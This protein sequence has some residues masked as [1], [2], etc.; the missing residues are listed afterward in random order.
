VEWVHPSWR[1]LVIEHLADDAAT[2]AHFLSGCSAHGVLL[3]LSLAGGSR[4]DRELPLLTSDPDWDAL[5]DRIYRLV[6]ELDTPELYAVLDS[7]GGAIGSLDEP[8]A[9]LEAKALARTVLSHTAELWD[10][11]RAPLPLAGLEAWLALADQLP[12]DPPR[13]RPPNLERTWVELLPAT[14]PSPEHRESVERFADWLT[15][16]DILREHR[17]GYL[18]RFHFRDHTPVINRFLDKIERDHRRLDPAAHDHALRALRRIETLVPSLLEVC[19]YFSS[20]LRDAGGE[21]TPEPW[22]PSAE[23]LAGEREGWRLFDVG[24]V[25]EDL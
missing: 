21:L 10:E 8:A 3:A 5:T 24:R 25:L 23:P 7:I 11:T 15:F 17:P 13:P 9:R 19:R 1:D 22:R 6:P 2:R 20:L 18:E 16:A 14:A 4:G 12:D